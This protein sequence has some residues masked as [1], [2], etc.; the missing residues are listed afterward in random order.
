MEFKVLGPLEVWTERGRLNLRGPKQQHVLAVLLLSNDRMVPV[1][2]L[3]DAAWQGNL[4]ATAMHQVRKIIADLRKNLGDKLIVTDGPGYRMHLGDEQLD[5]NLFDLRLARADEAI[6]SGL[7]ENAAIQ[8]DLGLQLWRDTALCGLGGPVLGPAIMQLDERRLAATERL[9]D[10]RLSLG[11]AAAV[12]TELHLLVQRHPLRENLR[13]QLMLALYRTGRQAEALRAYVDARRVLADEL[14]VDPGPHLS[15]LYEQVLRGDPELDV[16]PVAPAIRL[17]PPPAI[18]EEPATSPNMLPYSL[19]DFAGRAAEL[20]SVVERATAATDRG[21]LVIVTIDGMAGVG[22]T[23]LALHASYAIAD[24]FPDGQLFIDLRGHVE[25]TEPLDPMEAL[26]QLLQAVGAG[27]EQIPDELAAR[28]AMWRARMAGKRM[29]VVLDDA[30][31]IGQIRPLL[32]GAAGCLLLVTS[33]ARITDLDGVAPISLRPMTDQESIDMLGRIIGEAQV[34]ESAE[35]VRELVEVCGH[36]PLALRIVAARLRNRPMWTVADLVRRLRVEDQRLDELSVGNR[37]VSTAIEMSY[38][39][40]P[41]NARRLFRYIGMTLGKDFG[42]HAA[43][44]IADMPLAPTGRILEG[45]LDA[46]LLHQPHPD[47]YTLHGL[48]REYALRAGRAEDTES[49]RQ[50]A[51]RRLLDFYLVTAGEAAARIHPGRRRLPLRVTPP[52][53]GLP[54]LDS[55]AD[56]LAWFDQEQDGLFAAIAHIAE[57]GP[58]LHGSHLPRAMASYLQIRGRLHNHVDMLRVALSAAARSGDRTM[59]VMNLGALSSVQWQMGKVGEVFDNMWRALSIAEESGDRESEGECLSRI[60]LLSQSVGRYTDALSYLERALAIHRETGNL[61][62]EGVTLS[63]LSVV[64]LALGQ[65][66]SARDVGHTAMLLHRQLNHGVYTVS[67]METIAAAEL[68]LGDHAAAEDV[69]ERAMRRT[70]DIGFRAGEAMV[71]MRQADA[72]RRMGRLDDALEHGVQALELLW[73]IQRPAVEAEAMNILGAVHRER[74]EL[75]AAMSQYRNAVELAER[76]QCRLE[77][78]KALAGVG[79]VLAEMGDMDE[80][81]TQWRYALRHHEA[82]GTPWARTLRD[83]LCAHAECEGA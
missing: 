79:D 33:R 11:Q 60:G 40:L 31:D 68:E 4:P 18:V 52:A 27:G 65:Y 74:R 9:I 8:L 49:Q 66:Q 14:G 73:T 15:R 25:G 1:D 16:R 81:V 83:K 19:P 12:V 2:R 45:L 59:E 77:L 7:P 71:L 75:T 64:H 30:V 22:K 61:F 72:D 48:L 28:S 42:V 47:R 76:I 67:T 55:Q 29:L 5:L 37:S 78:G 41:F 34:S 3:V 38:R 35:E 36:L 44:A 10:L 62:E 50:E 70:Q 69:L 20:A 24:R 21:R 80:A 23:S 13:A 43:A 32:P 57:H 54:P 26:E 46:Q 58:D 17:G 39:R 53:A 51:F 56:G 6:A 82:M 63:S